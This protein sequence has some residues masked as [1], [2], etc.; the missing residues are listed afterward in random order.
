[1]LSRPSFDPKAKFCIH[2]A[3]SCALLLAACAPA[4][5][6]QIRLAGN[7][8]NTRAV[9]GLLLSSHQNWFSLVAE[10]EIKQ[11]AG[12][13]DE[14]N[15]LETVAFRLGNPNQARVEIFNKEGLLERTWIAN[16]VVLFDHDHQAVFTSQRNLPD[17]AVGLMAIPANVE[18]ISGR[19]A[20]PMAALIPTDLA[21]YIFPA[22]LAQIAGEYELASEE[23]IN[24]R[25]TWQLDYA[26]L[27]SGEEFRSARYWV[28]QQ[29]GI[30]LLAQYYGPE[31]ELL[32][33]Y[34]IHIR[35]L[36]G[37]IYEDY[38]RPWF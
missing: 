6:P 1:M 29:T 34:W 13:G 30:V 15:T 8:E 35:E 24:G 21:T 22:Q 18:A 19:Q 27:L 23:S 26:N 25:P 14:M 16:G 20:H 28:D 2:V 9:L 3:I 7:E 12:N 17:I 37:P 5:E 32:I 31:G 38:F 36:D 4:S 33:E 10:G 11:P